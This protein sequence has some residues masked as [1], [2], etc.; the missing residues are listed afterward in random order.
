M[1]LTEVVDHVTGEVELIGEDEPAT[2]LSSD[3]LD[4]EVC[5]ENAI[6][7]ARVITDGYN[8]RGEGKIR[9]PVA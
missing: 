7:L 1:S 4:L 9:R 3:A 5:V 6:T 8:E 2:E